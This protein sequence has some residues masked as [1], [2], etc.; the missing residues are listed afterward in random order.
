[1]PER[2]QI[3]ILIEATIIENVSALVHILASTREYFSAPRHSQPPI[4]DNVMS[5]VPCKL[6]ITELE[7]ER[8]T[9]VGRI[10][11]L[12]LDGSPLYDREWIID[13]VAP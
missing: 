6:L 3:A 8:I 11:F 5:F 2:K 4:P 7:A 1:M 9:R 13:E 10:E 12:Q